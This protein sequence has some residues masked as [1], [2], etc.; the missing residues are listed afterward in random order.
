MG[1]GIRGINPTDRNLF[2]W[3]VSSVVLPGNMY[4]RNRNYGGT[5]TFFYFVPKAVDCKIPWH[6][7]NLCKAQKAA[8]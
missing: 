2:A 5:Q 3:L 6:N 4:F 1:A 7:L 8:Q